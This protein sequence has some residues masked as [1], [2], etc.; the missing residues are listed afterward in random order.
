MT[1]LPE[2][3]RIVEVGPRDGLQNEPT[4][5]STADKL[6]LIER[7]VGAG[8]CDIEATSFVHP[9]LVPQLADAD[10]VVAALP[11]APGVV[12]SALV[13]NARG[14][15]RALSAGMQRIAVFTAASESFTQRNIRMSI[16][17]SLDVFGAVISRALAAGM[18]VR[19]YLS[20]C[21]ICPFEG[22]IAAARVAELAERMLALG[23]DEVAVSDTIGAAT[24]RRIF[25]TLGL[26]LE[27][28]PVKRVALHLHDTYG[29]ALANVLAGLQ[30]GVSTLDA[31]VGGFGG[32]PFAPGAAG[33]L[34]TEDLVYF[35]DDMG[36]HS[37]VELSAVVDAADAFARPLGIT[38]RSRQWRRLR[39]AAACQPG[40]TAPGT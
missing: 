40:R 16:D 27:R 10:R 15:E 37:G 4:P 25:D 23:V 3:V 12:Y 5:V 8:L 31:S 11:A 13:P 34:A 24:P 19:G 20:T 14:L 33:N 35:L 1:K 21:F 30:L 6:A 22:D 39:S 18:S 32:C 2:R 38:P 26:V 28:I 7:L 29:T 36:I 17:E 9:R